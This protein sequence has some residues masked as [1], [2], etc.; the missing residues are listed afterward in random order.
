MMREIREQNAE[1][2][3]NRT[4]LFLPSPAFPI[5]SPVSGAWIMLTH[6]MDFARRFRQTDSLISGISNQT[7]PKLNQKIVLAQKFKLHTQ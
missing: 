6:F 3:G 7:P 1:K 4:A 5:F 2:A